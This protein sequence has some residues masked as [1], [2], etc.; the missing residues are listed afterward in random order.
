VLIMQSPW[1]SPQKQP[2][3]PAKSGFN[4][5]ILLYIAC[6]A[7]AG[8]IGWPYIKGWFPD[9][10]PRASNHSGIEPYDYFGFKG[11]PGRF[12]R[13]RQAQQSGQRTYSPYFPSEGRQMP[14]APYTIDRRPG[15][16]GDTIA[17]SMARRPE[18][19][20]YGSGGGRRCIDT[21]TGRP[22]DPALC[23]RGE[24]LMAIVTLWI[25][26][27]EGGRGTIGLTHEDAV[28]ALPRKGTV[29]VTSFPCW[30]IRAL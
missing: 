29:A 24:A 21:Y 28:G 22:A 30:R 27:D 2:A 8:L 15:G 16:D 20:T 26:I 17:P 4:T 23:D 13:A 25:A 5:G 9:S 6:A 3:P 12:D 7:V 11:D 18:P 19:E 10:F 14:A 1:Q